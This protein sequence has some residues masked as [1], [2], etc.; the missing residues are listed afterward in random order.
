[1]NSK[2]TGWALLIYLLKCGQEEKEI[3]TINHIL[4]LRVYLKGH[5][6]STG[7]G[8]CFQCQKYGHSRRNC[9]A[10]KKF[11]KYKDNNIVNEGQKKRETPTACANCSGPHVGLY[12]GCIKIPNYRKPVT[13][14]A[15][16]TG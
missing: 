14:N 12:A 8:Q 4:R 2:I 1:M 13:E 16:G 10:E 7:L 5:G 9:C 15:T 6:G 3:W 11:V